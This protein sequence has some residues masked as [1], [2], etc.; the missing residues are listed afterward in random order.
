LIRPVWID[1][2]P[3]PAG[4]PRLHPISLIHELLARRGVRTVAAAAE[5]LDA[6]PRSAPDPTG[7]PNLQAAIDRI[8]GAIRT[9]ETIGIFG[10]YDADGVTATA[11][12]TRAL[13]AAAAPGL[14]QARLPRREQ[15]YGLNRQSID[16]LAA[17]GASLLVAVDCGSSDPVQVGYAQSLGLDVVVLDHHQIQC[18]PPPGAIVASAQLPGGERFVDLCSAGVAYMVASGLAQEGFRVGGGDGESETDLLDLV[19]LGTIGDV[20]PIN[21]LNRPLVRDGIAHLRK[22]TRPGLAALVKRA[23]IP[24]AAVDSES[25]AFRIGPRLNAAGRMADPRLAL[26][27]LLEDDP[28]EAA[29]LADHVEQLNE[30]RRAE[31][32]KLVRE[33]E[34]SIAADP[35]LLDHAI[36]IVSGRGWPGGL[37]GLVSSQL[38]ERY[39]RPAIVLADDGTKSHG[40][41]RSVPGFDFTAALRGANGLLLRFG[42]HGQA[43]GLTIAN[44]NLPALRAWLDAAI[45]KSGLSVPVPLTIP[46]AA[47]LQPGDLTFKTADLLAQLQPFG[48]GNAPPIFRLRNVAVRTY[49][50]VGQDKRHLRMQLDLGKGSVKAIGFGLADRSRELVANRRID[51]AAVMKTD[52][53][54]GQ[55]RLDLHIVDFRLAT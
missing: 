52:E 19:A 42:G 50:A 7:F 3:L 16:E 12:L 21:G 55:R 1:P 13:S 5:F 38:V 51:V 23:G 11:L 33:A 15:G 46:I 43:A 29:K 27:L 22:G 20:V 2:E 26:D 24:L 35:D 34:A 36:L 25:L 32:G 47:E 53:W 37:L 39:R 31:S 44:V 14:V 28:L 49:D 30:L 17:G 40:S 4:L 48:V 6:R 45:D 8:A 9:G 10:D 54:N 18:E 41:A